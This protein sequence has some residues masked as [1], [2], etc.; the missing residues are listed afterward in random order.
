MDKRNL[1]GRASASQGGRLRKSLIA[2][3]LIASLLLTLTAC[4]GGADGDNDGTSEK[5]INMAFTTAWGSFNP[6]YSTSTTMYELSLYD[7]IF[8]KLAFTDMAGADILPRAAT[9]WESADDG[10]AAIFYL[11][12][13]ASW[14]D[15]EKATAHDWAFTANL[16]AAPDSAFST[17]VFTNILAGTDADGVRIEGETFGAEAIDDTTFKLTFKEVTDPDDFLLH[18]N[19]KFL[20]LPE[21]LLGN[22]DPAKILDAEFWKNPVGSGPCVYVSQ[23]TGS[24]MTLA[25]NPYY[26]LGGGNW[27]KLVLRVLDSASRLTV[28]LSGEI[29]MIALGANISPDNVPTAEANG[30]EVYEGE[31]QNFFM[32]ALI[33]EKNIPDARIRQALHYAVDKD[34]IIASAQKDVGIP[35]YSYEMVNTVY[36]DPSLAFPRDVE[37]AKAL[38]KEAGYDGRAYTFAFASKRENIASLLAQQWQEAGI[39]INMVIVDVATMFSGLTSGAYDLGLS[40]HSASAYSLW[41]ETEFPANNTA[42]DYVPDPVRADYVARIGATIDKDAKIALVQEY[43]RYLAEQTWF[44]PIYFVGEYWVK[45]SRVSGI[46]N[47]ASLMCNDNVWE[48]YVN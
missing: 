19:R 27:D 15:G 22:V 31:T 3:S 40:G 39:N 41:F 45:T 34:A 9:R 38:L 42:P 1:C 47:S 7:K 33:N 25:P 30:F 21:H 36:H 18:Y 23:I 12:E 10:K 28:L 43:Q 48:W 5:V 4:G 46:K 35:A 2:L 20:V 16:L 24:E 29:D 17:R 6:Y 44:I 11:N 8:D 26:Q 13:N 37:K 32:E 14:S